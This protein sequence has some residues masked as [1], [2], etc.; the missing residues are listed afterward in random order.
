MISTYLDNTFHAFQKEVGS[1]ES[2]CSNAMCNPQSSNNSTMI[3]YFKAS[4][5]TD[6]FLVPW[7]SAALVFR[8]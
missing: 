8:I 6:V 2:E 1:L 5:D 7:R 3:D 4:S